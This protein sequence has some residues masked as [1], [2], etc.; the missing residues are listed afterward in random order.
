M[1]RRLQTHWSYTI[2]LQDQ[3]SDRLFEEDAIEKFRMMRLILKDL[4][5][6]YERTDQ[7]M[8]RQ[9]QKIVPNVPFLD[10]FVFVEI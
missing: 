4:G 8:V 3:S 10:N 5:T 2:C 6:N 1:D 7:N 9:I